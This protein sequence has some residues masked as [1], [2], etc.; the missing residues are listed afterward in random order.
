MRERPFIG[1][2]KRREPMQASQQRSVDELLER[3]LIGLK[4]TANF[5][6]SDNNHYNNQDIPPDVFHAPVDSRDFR[7]RGIRQ[8]YAI[9][10]T[11]GGTSLFFHGRELFTPEQAEKLFTKGYDRSKASTDVFGPVVSQK[12]RDTLLPSSLEYRLQTSAYLTRDENMTLVSNELAVAKRRWPEAGYEKLP[13]LTRENPDAFR[14]KLIALLSSKLDDAYWDEVLAHPLSSQAPKNIAEHVAHYAPQ[15]ETYFEDRMHSLT[16]KQRQRAKACKSELFAQMAQH[17]WDPEMLTNF[18]V[19]ITCCDNPKA[20]APELI[21]AGIEQRIEDLKHELLDATRTM[22]NPYDPRFVAAERDVARTLTSSVHPRVLQK[23][24]KHNTHFLVSDA[25]STMPGKTDLFPELSS[26]GQAR[27]SSGFY[28]EK[29][30]YLHPD[31]ADAVVLAA[32]QL[33]FSLLAEYARHELE[34]LVDANSK[35]RFHELSP[36]VLDEAFTKDRQTLSGWSKFLESINI[37]S[38]TEDLEKMYTLAKLVGIAI[39][40]V[41]PQH[42]ITLTRDALLEVT[43]NVEFWVESFMP[44]PDNKTP[45][46]ETREKQLQETPAIIAQLK[47]AYGNP[48]VRELLPE[49]YKLTTMHHYNMLHRG[50]DHKERSL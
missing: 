31:C 37:D 6:L 40:K 15:A 3:K 1:K 28:N 48:L 12:I 24:L 7:L 35:K 17:D 34:H 10:D 14:K 38:P 23:A 16:A 45:D 46:Y 47:G 30:F 26:Q 22:G 4:L 41:L 27:S 32:P 43:D 9:I 11:V 2:I 36:A 49:T 19:G 44:S 50:G 33:D 13:A 20:Q 25:P 29:A 21:A 8:N 42:D 5:Q 18:L 39:P